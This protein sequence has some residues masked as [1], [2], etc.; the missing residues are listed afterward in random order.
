MDL[1]DGALGR[2]HIIEHDEGLALG[3]EVRL[4][5]E[6]DDIAVFREDVRQGFFELVDFDPLLQVA[7]LRYVN[8][9]SIRIGQRR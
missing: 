8:R 7:N 4:G 1:L 2:F 5:D 6:I 9:S 3:L